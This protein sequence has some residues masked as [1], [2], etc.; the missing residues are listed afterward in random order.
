MS[1]YFIVKVRT[2]LFYEI[3][4][5]FCRDY[6]IIIKKGDNMIN[7][8]FIHQKIYNDLQTKIQ[9]EEFKPGDKLPKE[10]ELMIHYDCSRHTIRKA[11]ENLSNEGYIYTIKGKGTF[12]KEAKSNYGLSQMSSFS[13]ILDNQKGSPNSVIYEA[14]EILP[15]ASIVDKLG[16]E[17]NESVY[18][19]ERVRR[20]GTTNLSFEKVYINKKLCPNIIKH[21][22]PY[23]S[24]FDLYEREYKLSLEEGVYNLEAACANEKISNILDIEKNS[25][26]L[27]MNALI[28]ISTGEKLYFVKAY[29]IGNRYIFSTRLK[30]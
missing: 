23:S 21:V 26:V 27:L 19:I 30:R 2:Y 13:E 24:L 4:C 28:D 10:M 12:I 9:N 7:N 14:K 25:A 11:L 1:I 29:Y 20:N 3:L 16:L 22:T 15:P 17:P 5:T 8:N 18:Y 6:D